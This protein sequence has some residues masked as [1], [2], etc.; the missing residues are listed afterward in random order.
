MIQELSGDEQPQKKRKAIGVLKTMTSNK[1]VTNLVK[2]K[3]NNV[4]VIVLGTP[5]DDEDTDMEDMDFS[6]G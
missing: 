3:K 6:K 5:N 1:Q 4:E 2:K